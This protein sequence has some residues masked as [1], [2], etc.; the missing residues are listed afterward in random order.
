M[1]KIAP[2]SVL[3]ILPLLCLAVGCSRCG[4]D[5]SK[6]PTPKV[7]SGGNASSE[8]NDQS[9]Y[10]I[11]RSE[12]EIENLDAP[13]GVVNE[14][15]KTFFSGDDEGAFALL[16]SKARDAQRDQFSAQKSDTIR[17]RVS[18]KSKAKR[19][20]VHV[21]VD[22][23]DFTDSGDIQMDSLTFML[24]DDMGKWR[25][26]GFQVGDLA[27]NFEESIIAST[28]TNDAE[29]PRTATTERDGVIR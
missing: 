29:P 6:T 15:F 5:A 11:D 25:V 8:S 14:F 13:E 22:V 23:E 24:V 10:E 28:E 4:G 1:R 12:I 26:A 16:S 9:D 18:Q 17:W 7:E 2:L 21:W 20:A 3:L 27:V 19:G